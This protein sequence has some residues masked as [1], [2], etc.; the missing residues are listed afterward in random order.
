MCTVRD[1]CVPTHHTESERERANIEKNPFIF[2]MV[3]ERGR[4]FGKSGFLPEIR[5][6]S[7]LR[8]S[9]SLKVF[10]RT[11]GGFPH[12]ITSDAVTRPIRWEQHQNR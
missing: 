4:G 3:E 5:Q 8:L 1:P 10:G 6:T 12:Q 11:L 7:S 9:Q 2:F